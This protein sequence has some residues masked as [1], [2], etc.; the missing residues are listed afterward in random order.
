MVIESDTIRYL[1][2]DFLLRPI[3]KLVSE[4]HHCRDTATFWSQCWVS[5]N[6]GCDD[7]LVIIELLSEVCCRCC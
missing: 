7:C 4:M 5:Y 2:Y 6:T 1:G 3:V